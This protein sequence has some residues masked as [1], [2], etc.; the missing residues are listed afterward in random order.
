MRHP[1]AVLVSG[2]TREGLVELGERIERELSHRLR[3]GELLVPDTAGAS[4]AELHELAGEVSREDTA[5]GV[6]VRRADP[7]RAWPSASRASPSAR[8]AE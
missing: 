2:T 7:A 5:E 8:L 4:L 6:R 1:E 3:A